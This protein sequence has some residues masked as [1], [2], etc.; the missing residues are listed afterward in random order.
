MLLLCL[1]VSTRA[2]TSLHLSTH[3]KWRNPLIVDEQHSKVCPHFFSCKQEYKWDILL[4]SIYNTDSDESLTLLS[5]GHLHY[6]SVTTHCNHS[7]RISYIGDPALIPSMFQIDASSK[8]SSSRF[9]LYTSKAFC[10]GQQKYNYC[11]TFYH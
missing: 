10:T 8:L 9:Y 11:L 4:S 2:Q 3:N 5:T 6:S 1:N 7:I